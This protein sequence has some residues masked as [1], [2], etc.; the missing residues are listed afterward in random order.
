VHDRAEG[1]AAEPAAEAPKAAPQA[2]GG[3]APSAWTVDHERSAIRFSGTYGGAPMRGVFG[4]WRAEI[5]FDPANLDASQAAV[6]I[7]TAAARTGISELDGSLSAA[8]AFDTANHPTAVFRTTRIRHLGGDNYEARG[9]LT[10]KGRA[11]DV[12]APFTLTIASDRATVSGRTSIDR[13]QANVG[14][15][16]DP[17]ASFVSRE[18]AVD[19]AIQ[20]TRN[21]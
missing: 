19:F 4:R 21:R 17:G 5:R 16:T 6:T 14:M 10:L 11:L 2:P 20:A 9:T 1:A 8:E 13:T 7:E 18:I 12:T 15:T 3:A